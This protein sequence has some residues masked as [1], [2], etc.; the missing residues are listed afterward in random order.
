MPFTSND[1]IQ[2]VKII[3]EHLKEMQIVIYKNVFAHK[4]RIKLR[5]KRV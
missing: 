4:K 2:A 5:I 1:T 3:Q